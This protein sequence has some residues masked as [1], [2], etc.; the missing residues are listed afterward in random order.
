MQS[1]A[2]TQKEYEDRIKKVRL[3]GANMGPHDYIPTEWNKTATS[4]RV[5][6][7][8]CRVCFTRVNMQLLYEHFPEAKV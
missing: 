4:E 7:V 5:T 1:P 8:M 6:H 2:L 3:C